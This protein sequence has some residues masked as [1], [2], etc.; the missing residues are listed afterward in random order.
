MRKFVLMLVVASLA[1]IA[2]AARV[3]WSI[4]IR[5]E[6]TIG[7]TPA[8]SWNGATVYSYVIHSDRGNVRDVISAWASDSGYTGSGDGNI[9]GGST[10][11]TIQTDADGPDF[12]SST[13]VPWDNVRTDYPGYIVVILAQED[14]SYAYTWYGQGVDSEMFWAGSTAPFDSQ[15][16]FGFGDSW[17]V[18]QVPEPTA[19]A[20]LALSVAGLA[21]RR[22]NA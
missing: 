18:V 8:S 19:F 1:V 15:Y 22:R 16:D 2:S 12:T 4:D 11:K 9:C 3:D 5:G 7:S 17:T 13:S 21:L 10:G 6:G 20:L 14:G